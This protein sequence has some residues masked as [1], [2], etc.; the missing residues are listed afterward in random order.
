MFSIGRQLTSV[1]T[2]LVLATSVAAQTSTAP[3]SDAWR[4]AGRLLGV[5]DA[6]SG[7]PIQDA[8]VIDV[9]NDVT[10]RT[11]ASG[12]ITLGFLPVGSSLVQIR[13]VGF[14]AETLL[15]S[16]T[17]RDTAPITIVLNPLTELAAV[18][19]TDSAPRYINANLRAFEQRRKV[20]IGHFVTEAQLRKDDGLKLSHELGR[21]P[22]L[23]ISAKGNGTVQS[24]RGGCTP[25]VFLDGLR[26]Q[27][28]RGMPTLGN[29]EVSE[30]G[31]IEYYTSAQIPA[32]FNQTSAACGAIL[33][34]TRER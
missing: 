34:W 14:A 9:I 15:V 8:E 11:P 6:A 5:Y 25:V 7:N 13:K 21:I 3:P 23:T 1:L 20:G 27:D 19:I 4:R 26:L 2:A 22:G 24:T 10:V 16:I 32:Q 17:A 18:V 12:L 29:W 28:G 33:I 31:A 30:V